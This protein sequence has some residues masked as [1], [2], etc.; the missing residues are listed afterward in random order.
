MS[1]KTIYWPHNI[2]L[3][4]IL[5]L[6][7]LATAGLIFVGLIGAAFS[8]VG[9]SPL[10]VVLILVATFLG[11]FINIPLFKIKT[12]VPTV[13]EEYANFFGVP[14]RIPQASC[15]QSVTLI[16]IN[17]GGALIPTVVSIYLL[18]QSAH[19]DY[20]F[21]PNRHSHRGSNNQS[22]RTASQRSRHRH[23]STC[24]THSRSSNSA[25]FSSS[26]SPS[27]SL[28]RRRTGNTNRRRPAKP[29][30]N[31]QVGCASRQ[32][33]RRRNLR[34]RIFKRHNSSNPS[35]PIRQSNGV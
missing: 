9:F 34:R 7:L 22:H 17:L 6:I 11:S 10:I 26:T 12:C 16:A 25:H 18:S 27:H 14:Y 32:H 1:R 8:E 33:R 2:L 20:S 31:P 21:L 28:H 23:T 3:F 13:K 30:Q 29:W 35:R 19:T 4:G 24:S 15:E 5:L